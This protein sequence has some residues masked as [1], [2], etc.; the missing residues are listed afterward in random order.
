MDRMRELVALLNKYAHEYYVL[1]NPSITDE[2]YD[3]L[4]D[5]LV[6]LESELM[7]RLPDSPTLRV[8]GDT[9]DG[10]VG[11]QHRQRLFSLDKVKDIIG[12]E[13]YFNRL[14]KSLGGLPRFT[15]EHKFD[16]LTLSLTYNKG[17]LVTGATRGDGEV[18][19]DVTAQ[20]RTIKTVPL[21]IKHKGLIE[22]QG[23][24]IMRLSVFEEYNKTAAT[25]LKNPRNAAAG[26]IRNLNPNVTAER[27]LDFIAYNVGHYEGVEFAAQT[28]VRAFLIENGFYVDSEFYQIDSIEN[29]ENALK[30]IEDGRNEL[31]FLIDGAVFKVDDL[32]IREELGFTQK[33]PRWALAYKFRA[34]EVATVVEGVVW[35]VSRTSKIN[36]LALLTPV[37]LDGVTVKRAT[38]NNITDIQRKGVRIGSRV[39]LRRSNDVIP[40]IMGVISHPPDSREIVV[41]KACPACGAPVREDSVFVYCTNPDNC[42]PTIVSA[43]DH[44]ASKGAMD[45]DG[46]S[47]RTAE[48][49]YNDLGVKTFDRLYTLTEEELLTLEGFKEKKAG[50]LIAAIAKSK[51]A[52]LS[53][54][55]FALG[56]T[57]I[58]KKGAKT[59][60]DTFIT[61]DAIKNAAKEEIVL[62]PDFGEIMA[63]SVVNYFSSPK[64]L[65]VI[66]A[67]FAAGVTPSEEVNTQANGVFLGKVVV[68][69]GSLENYK[70]SAAAA[71]ISE[72]GGQV[73]DSVNKKVNLVVAGKDA[74]SKLEKAK[75]LG[76]EIIDEAEFVKLL[77]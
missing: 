7:M 27:K 71:L 8:G 25:P 9:I 69:T 73:A 23:E 36:P 45:I 42:A 30:K 4:Y 5:E 39:L 12:L 53:R 48:Q 34:L 66:E 16:G 56:I 76:I 33:F 2:E 28:D 35:Q 46:L 38:L 22:I 15:L 29:A 11:Y 72:R 1:D 10:F 13:G 68:L 37:N 41:P 51:T 57:N 18:G 50:N 31:D 17:K 26:A 6:A 54:F 32:A 64:N 49:L 21:S 65:A 77:E 40:E 74:G 61:F 58:G 59:L 47:E 75:K 70:R 43:L 55:I 20:I 24:G 63:E 44:F 60:A 52:A 3:N 19:E 67:A 14:E 62:I